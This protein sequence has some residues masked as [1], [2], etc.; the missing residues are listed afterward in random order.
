MAKGDDDW[1]GDEGRWT[2]GSESSEGGGERYYEL[3]D[4]TVVEGEPPED[5]DAE[6]VEPPEEEEGGLSGLFGGDDGDDEPDEEPDEPEDEDDD[7]SI[8]P[9]VVG[10]VVVLLVLLVLLVAA[11]FLNIADPLGIGDTLGG[12]GGTDGGTGGNGNGGGGGGNDTQ[13]F[14]YPVNWSES[15]FDITGHASGR[16]EGGQPAN[17]SSFSVSRTNLLE[18]TF[19]VRYNDSDTVGVDVGGMTNQNDGDTLQ[20]NVTSPANETLT[21]DAGDDPAANS[22]IAVSVTFDIATIPT[23]PTEI[24]AMSRSNATQQLMAEQPPSTDGTGTYGIEVWFASGGNSCVENSAGD[25]DEDW[26]LDVSYSW[27]EST[28]GQGVE[29]ES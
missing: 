14:R 24:E 28:L 23:S 22:D 16:A 21:A 27:Y 4:G 9:I 19:T 3:P 1:E 12:D 7:G 26:T 18:V 20:L 11:A 17:T 25:C 15:S 8:V 6:P 5:V 13:L 10:V 29:V 2:R